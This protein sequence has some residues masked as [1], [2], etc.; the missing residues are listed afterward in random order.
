MCT[1]LVAMRPTSSS[2]FTAIRWFRLPAAIPATACS[3]SE[4][5]RSAALSSH[6]MIRLPTST[7]AVPVMPMVNHRLK[8]CRSSSAFESPT[9]K[10][11]QCLP[12][13]KMGLEI[14]AIRS[15]L[16]RR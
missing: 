2:P 11:P 8:A 6:P 9:R 10:A 7:M 5:G 13:T 4:S 14:S 16:S 1:R 3:I 15:P 12:F